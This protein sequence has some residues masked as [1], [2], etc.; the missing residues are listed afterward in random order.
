MSHCITKEFILYPFICITFVSLFTNIAVIYTSI[1]ILVTNTVSTIVSISC[2]VFSHPC[3]KLKLPRHIQTTIY[4]GL[5]WTRKKD[6]CQILKIGKRKKM[7]MMNDT[8]EFSVSEL[9]LLLY[10][11]DAFSSC[12]ETRNG[13]I[14]HTDN[15]NLL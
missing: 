9:L 1:D 13:T 3:V 2:H 15:K 10:L 7:M 4:F 5:T 12:T 6:K 8:I 11:V 14:T